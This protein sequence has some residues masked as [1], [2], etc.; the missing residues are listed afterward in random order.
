MVQVQESISP[1]EKEKS[2]LLITYSL[3]LDL[4][5]IGVKYIGDDLYFFKKALM[6]LTVS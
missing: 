5:K 3:I 2:Y 6:K 1:K 4:A